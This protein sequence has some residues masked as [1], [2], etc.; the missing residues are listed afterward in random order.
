MSKYS[1]LKERHPR[2]CTCRNLFLLL[3]L[4][5]SHFFIFTLVPW[6]NFVSN[7][8]YS[9][10]LST[11]FTHHVFPVCSSLNLQT[12]NIRLTFA[13][14]ALLKTSSKNSASRSKCYFFFLLFVQIET[15]IIK[16]LRDIEGNHL[17]FNCFWIVSLPIALR[18]KGIN[19][20]L[21]R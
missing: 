1:L 21:L 13:S 10:F 14:T 7:Q 3:R 18:R 2:Y 12:F 5:F 9:I 8:S 17:P 19:L 6:C 15:S 4:F 20:W 16:N 11:I